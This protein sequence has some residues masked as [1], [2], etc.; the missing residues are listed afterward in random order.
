MG[1][2]VM[3]MKPHAPYNWSKFQGSPAALKWT[4]RDLPNLDRTVE[5]VPQKRVA[6]QAGGNLGI[7]AK[8][9][10]ESFE[11]VYSFE[12][13]G[14]LFAMMTANAPESNIYRYQA[15]LGFDRDMVGVSRQRRDGKPDN[16]EGI[17]HIYGPGRI[18]TLRLDDLA[19]PECDLFVLDVEGW[20]YF[21]LKGAVATIRRC[22]P[23]LS[24]EINKN[25]AFVDINPDDVRKFV[26][27]LGYRFVEKLQSDEIFEPVNA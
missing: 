11:A 1:A 10:A 27:D 4:R 25:A 2:G 9:L 17:T 24:V 19:L 18:P 15:A 8:R 21:A 26:T 12:P 20:E 16:H 6:V 23:W 13:A 14:D 3:A 7:Y 22:R 5:R